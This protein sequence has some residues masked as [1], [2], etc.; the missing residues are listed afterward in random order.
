MVALF[1]LLLRARMRALLLLLP[2]LKCL[3]AQ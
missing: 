1:C 3:I 2:S